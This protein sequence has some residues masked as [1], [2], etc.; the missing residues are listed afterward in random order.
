ML[1]SGDSDS[2]IRTLE[3]SEE[4]GEPAETP[5]PEEPKGEVEEIQVMNPETGAAEDVSKPLQMPEIDGER[6]Q[7]MNEDGGEE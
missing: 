3:A 1:T 6:K 4:D 5:Q 7:K 2:A